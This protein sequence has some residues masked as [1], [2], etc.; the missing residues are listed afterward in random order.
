MHSE[1][2]SLTRF[3]IILT[4]RVLFVFWLCFALGTIVETD[5]LSEMGGSEDRLDKISWATDIVLSDRSLDVVEMMSSIY[6]LANCLIWFCVIF[7]LTGDRISLASV[8]LSSGNSHIL[9]VRG[10]M[11]SFLRFLAFS[12]YSND[13]FL[14]KSCIVCLKYWFI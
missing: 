6:S 1:T 10:S 11:I 7:P 4:L 2:V 13:L 12:C 8:T 9:S 14:S 3:Q 5:L